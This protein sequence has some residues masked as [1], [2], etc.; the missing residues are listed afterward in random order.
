MNTFWNMENAE[1]DENNRTKSINFHI[2]IIF[3]DVTLIRLFF[4]YFSLSIRL[5][6]LSVFVFLRDI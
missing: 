2:K 5:S 1:N 3:L 4:L 6:F